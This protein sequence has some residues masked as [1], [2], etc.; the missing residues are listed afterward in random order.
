[1]P[2]RFQSLLFLHSPISQGLLIFSIAF[3]GSQFFAPQF[4]SN[5]VLLYS[6]LLQIG[7]VF[8]I[9]FI[10]ARNLKLD[11]RAEFKLKRTSFKNLASSTLV[12]ISLI[13]L[14]QELTYLQSR[15]LG[16]VFGQD[17]SIMEFLKVNTASDFGWTF[18]AIGL[19][20]AFCEEFLFRGFIFNRLLQPNQVG[21]A[22]MLSSVLFGV[23][24][25]QLSVLLNNTVAGIVLSLI[26]YRSGSLFN[27][28]LAHGVINAAAIVLVNSNQMSSIFSMEH[29]GHLP[30]P[31]LAASLA[32]LAFGL[33]GLCS[34][35][36]SKS[37]PY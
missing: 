16:E 22:I 3:L 12:A 36:T 1:M 5:H 23:F 24:H 26:V 4:S 35:E 25:R 2:K 17:F 14:L 20:P 8:G 18:L 32:G 15:F 7:L 11:T 19:V 31:L 9:P 30:F 34:E 28:I 13:A 21:Q 10:M 29:N 27:S 6:V 33:M 37:A